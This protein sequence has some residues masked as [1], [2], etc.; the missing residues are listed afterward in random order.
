VP[1]PEA[2]IP[3]ASSADWTVRETPEESGTSELVVEAAGVASADDAA[4]TEDAAVSL[5]AALLG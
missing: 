3:V 1:S 5:G 4:G 2:G